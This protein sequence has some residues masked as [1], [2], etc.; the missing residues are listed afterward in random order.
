MAVE[1]T[2]VKTVVVGSGSTGQVVPI[3]FAFN[4]NAEI[5]AVLTDTNGLDSDLTIGTQYTLTGAG[6]PSGGEL[7]THIAVGAGQKLTVVLDPPLTQLRSYNPND[8]FPA[9]SHE[10]ALD[11][12]T[13]ICQ[14]LAERIGRTFQISESGTIATLANRI[15]GTDAQGKFKQLTLA[16]TRTAIGAAATSHVHAWDDIADPPSTFPPSDHTHPVIALNPSTPPV[17]S[18]EV[19]ATGAITV[20]G[21]PTIGETLTIGGVVYTFS[22]S[23]VH[24]LDILVL[25][26]TNNAEIAGSIAATVNREDNNV[27]ATVSGSTVTLTAIALKAKGN[28]VTLAK[29]ASTLTLSAATLAGGGQATFPVA[30]PPTEGEHLQIAIVANRHAFL[31]VRSGFSAINWIL[32]S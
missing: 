27:V 30:I 5:R 8:N 10:G 17:S 22:D 3:P 15:F 28:L 20:T 26:P 9:K 19:K 11:K 7:T 23:L 6:N 4:A 13:R 2:T 14:R 31:C 29:T 16:E 12:L 24:P 25:S 18:G 21:I 32:I 1:S